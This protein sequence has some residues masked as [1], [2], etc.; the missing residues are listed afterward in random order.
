MR[1]KLHIILI[2]FLLILPTVIIF[3]RT[4]GLNS[5]PDED[6][7][8]TGSSIIYD[9]LRLV[10]RPMKENDL[11]F[12]MENEGIAGAGDDYNVMINGTGTGLKPPTLNEWNAIASSFYMVD[13]V[14]FASPA[15]L[16]TVKLH[17]Q[18]KYFPPIGN[19]GA[20]GSCV[21]WS[22]GYY[23]KTWQ[24]AK[25]QDWNLSGATM[26]GTWPGQ[27]SAAYQD[28]IMSP[29]F[30][31]HQVNNGVDGGS[32]YS[33]TIFLCQDTGICSWK[34]MPYNC[35]NSTSWPSEAAWREAP[36]YRSMKNATYYMYVQ[37]NATINN[38]KTWIDGGNLAT[39]SIN[40]YRYD[41]LVNE[42]WNNTVQ[43]GSGRNHANTIIGYDDNFGPY[44]EDG[45]SR[46]GAF[47]VA[48][49][50]G[51]GWSGDSNSDGMYWI[52]YECMRKKVQYVFLMT[53]MIDYEPKAI[54]LFN[55]THPV[56]EECTITLGIGSKTS[57]LA[58]KKRYDSFLY[59]G[60]AQPFP[61]NKMAY[62][63]TEFAGSVSTFIGYNYFIK[64]QDGGSS[65]T[66]SIQHFSIELFDDYS[67]GP[68]H[69]FTSNDPVVATINGGTV[70][71]EVTATDNDPPSLTE[72]RTPSSATTGDPLNFTIVVT[73]NGLM[74]K[75][76]VEYRSGTGPT[77]NTTMSDGAGDLWYLNITAPDS[78]ENITYIFH[79]SD[80][81]G[82]WNETVEKTI[83][84]TDND[85]PL[86]YPSVPS[87][88]TTG[89][90]L[91]MRVLVT[92][93]IGVGDVTLEHWYD[94]GTHANST[95]A[96]LSGDNWTKTLNVENRL[97]VL[98]LLIKA[99]DT[100]G[101]MKNSQ[102]YDLYVLDNDLP[103]FGSDL[104]DTGS[105]TGET[106]KLS[107][108]VSDNIGISS[109]WASYQNSDGFSGNSSMNLAAPGIWEIHLVSPDSTSDISYA[110]HFNDTSDNWNGTA[111][112][113]VSIKDNDLPFF[114]ADSTP[115]IGTTGETFDFLIEVDDNIQVSA[116]LL[117][118][119][120]GSGTHQN[121]S[122]SGSGPYSLSIMV[123]G[124]STDELRYLVHASDP[125]GNWNQTMEAAVAIIDNDLPSY[126]NDAS[127][128]GG[129]TG[130]TFRFELTVTDNIGIQD[131]L[132]EYWFGEGKHLNSSMTGPSPYILVIDIPLDKLDTLHY[133][134]HA[135]DEAGN[136]NSTAQSD[137]AILDDDPP[138]IGSDTTPGDGR[139]GD[140]FSF[141]VQVTDNIEVASVF[142]EYWFGEGEHE[143]ASMTGSGFYHLT[144]NIP[145]DSLET[146]HYL[147]WAGDPSGN[148][149]N[150]LI[151]DIGIIDDD[152]PSMY[153]DMS[154]PYATTGDGYEI[155]VSAVDNLGIE[156]VWLVYW[157]G[158][159]QHSNVSMVRSSSFTFLIAVPAD[160][161]DELFYRVHFCDGAGNWNGTYIR[162]ITVNDNDI[163]I[164]AK[165]DPVNETGTGSR[166]EIS[167]EVTDNIG[168]SSVKLEYWFGTE[169]DHAELMMSDEGSIFTAI[170][171]IPVDSLL[172]LHYSITA[173]DLSGSSNTTQVRDVKVIDTIDPEITSLEDIVVYVGREVRV[174]ILATDN[175]GIVS[176]IWEGAPIGVDGS[177]L[178]W[179]ASEAGS[180]EVTLSA[181]DDQGNSA[182]ASFTIT[183]L[184]ID[185]DE[186]EDGMPD[187]F[188][189]ENGLDSKDPEDAI[190]DPDDDGLSNLEEFLNGTAMNNDDTDGD[191]M[192][193]GWEVR[194]NLDPK[195]PS[196]TNDQDEDGITDLDE[197]HGGTDP[198]IPDIV[199]GPEEEN[200]EPFDLLLPA[201][202][203]AGI[204]L[205]IILVIVLFVVLRK[206]KKGKQAKGTEE[207]VMS[208]D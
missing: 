193:D 189:E 49:S 124:D 23:T 4:E 184:P 197:Y 47:L 164:F 181:L 44:Q 149:N 153:M 25:D 37:T 75:V 6:E 86:V 154:G 144:I 116:V 20:E 178:V 48:N 190:L 100:S 5:F 3:G 78:L 62:D 191:G 81:G 117:E 135:V 33:D 45:T 150:T 46:R 102:I 173:F 121:V 179:M 146:L 138:E 202:I 203:L 130:D 183:I 74:D 22:V 109:V 67:T 125:S 106:F 111:P 95:M 115:A 156:E 63:I 208:W 59:D 79:A 94:S 201:I 188:E 110:F 58:T 34:E 112:G 199:I 39:I 186:D 120:F 60:G 29:D 32:Y 147:F 21:S 127:P 52:S 159:G 71:A 89:D 85:D 152:L 142:V 204:V 54:A 13:E 162:N 15:T 65:T 160:S 96:F 187:L 126:L 151:V 122:M 194:Y 182:D 83:L 41:S 64:V 155:N 35:Y 17:N 177:E 165:D 169:G 80:K 105:T 180:F 55:I 61:S 1:Y 24:E 87:K 145:S 157:F 40:A 14:A 27:P 31:Y 51:K 200:D 107:A 141:A 113:S 185:H 9:G 168:L 195:V 98:H 8:E 7:P 101:N 166:F 114:G 161:L 175:I 97:G 167:I 36:L 66:G 134:F 57:P 30:L 108:A 174:T 18:S 163:P 73:D 176:Y 206:V 38:L 172:E 84:M 82:N 132:V 131:V 136:W 92:D 104:S 69:R 192:P 70:Y 91:A 28:K 26:G 171:D 99:R 53:D 196:S 133:L 12:F 205:A 76:T 43:C 16:S 158:E 72:D 10:T 68:T 19:Q 207:E 118:Y 137:V 140:P 129:T 56:R 50:W 128:S 148:W 139:T 11:E 88:A 2:A 103:A 119:W 90:P 42:V 170:V 143:N 198:L 77:F 123:P 93:N